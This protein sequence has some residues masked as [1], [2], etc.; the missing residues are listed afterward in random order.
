[1]EKCYNVN[2]IQYVCLYSR[3]NN[4]YNA[5]QSLTVTYIQVRGQVHLRFALFQHLD[6]NKYSQILL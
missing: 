3:Q 1:M 6:Y 4:R 2:G 5:P